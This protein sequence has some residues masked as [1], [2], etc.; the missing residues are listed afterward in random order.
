MTAVDGVSFAVGAGEAVGLVGESGCGKSTLARVVNRLVSLSGG[1]VRLDGREIGAIPPARFSRDPARAAVQMVFQD[2]TDSLD[3]HLTAFEAIAGPV[4]TLAGLDRAGVMARVTEAAALA[5]LPGELLGRYP[6]QLSGGQKARVGIA[7]A[8]GV[9]PRLLV[10]DE[11]TSALDVSVQAV[12][13]RLFASLRMELGMA[14]LFI[15]HDLNVVRLVCDRVLVMYLGRV[16]ETGPVA[17]VFTA[18][19]HPYTRALIDAIPDPA[20]RGRPVV[21]ES[22]VGQRGAGCAFAPRCP[23]V[24]DRCRVEQPALVAGVAC[25]RAE[26]PGF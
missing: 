18:P 14:L 26:P 10:L 7:R 12:V 3:P 9:R 21:L 6:H 4:R 15:S 2:A 24:L 13:L 5:G 11:P 25:H 17:D 8:V 19:R 16:V 20:R 22:E 23:L 1:S